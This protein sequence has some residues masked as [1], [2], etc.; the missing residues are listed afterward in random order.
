MSE[1]TEYQKALVR[2]RLAALSAEH[3]RA[4]DSIEKDYAAER[5]RLETMLR[6]GC[7]QRIATT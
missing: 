6:F 5:K 7:P 2:E 3:Y 1:L 4:V